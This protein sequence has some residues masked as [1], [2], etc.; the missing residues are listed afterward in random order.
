MVLGARLAK[1]GGSGAQVHRCRLAGVEEDLAVK[2]LDRARAR[3]GQLEVLTAEVELCRRLHGEGG[4][5]S[6]VRFLHLSVEQLIDGAGH[7]AIVME[8]LPVSL[9]E[10]VASRAAATPTPRPFGARYL[11]GLAWQLA[12]AL[13][14][15]HGLS[16]TVLHRDVKPA[17][18]F[19]EARAREA[20][21]GA[22]DGAADADA[23]RLGRLR[24]GDFDVSVAAAAPLT[25]FVGTPTVSTPPEMF[26]HEPHH[27]PADVWAYGMTLQWCLMLGDPLAQ[28]TMAELEERL[29]ATPQPRLPLFAGAPTPDTGD[30]AAPTPPPPGTCWWPSSLEPMA[31]LARACC[32]SGPSARLSA[33]EIR[34]RLGSKYNCDADAWPS[35]LLSA[36]AER[37]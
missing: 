37:V 1:A 9:E 5:P 34:R 10:L 35:N 27:R 32:C 24:L 20:D 23:A 21:A 16:P 36:G 15:L 31:E 28:T 30:G 25:E 19:F 33:D 17:N 18:V 12:D 29:L 4:A 2:A 8:L 11:A 26:R 6:I 22:E 13:A 3:P 7:V 14:H